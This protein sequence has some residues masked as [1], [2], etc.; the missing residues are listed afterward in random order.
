MYIYF[1]CYVCVV[2]CFIVLFCV[3]FVCKCILYYCHRVQTQLQRKYKMLLDTAIVFW[4]ITAT[5]T[6]NSLTLCG[7]LSIVSSSDTQDS[8]HPHHCVGNVDQV[9]KKT[10][11]GN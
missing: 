7:Q 10:A 4:T 5:L 8:Q 6:T 3:L 1:Y 9:L 11:G 2:F